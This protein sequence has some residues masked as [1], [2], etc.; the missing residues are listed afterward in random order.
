MAAGKV[1][2]R[3]NR[4]DAIRPQKG[5]N[6]TATRLKQDDMLVGL[7]GDGRRGHAFAK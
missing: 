7:H 2:R 5:L 3:G 4:T 1:H 6:M